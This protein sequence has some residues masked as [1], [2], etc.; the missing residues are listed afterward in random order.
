M[1]KTQV[2][3]TFEKNMQRQTGGGCSEWM[4]KTKKRAEIVLSGHVRYR[5]RLNTGGMRGMEAVK[6]K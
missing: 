2:Q 6:T 4:L 5:N 3:C 1:I